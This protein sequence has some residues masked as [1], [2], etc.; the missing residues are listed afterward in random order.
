MNNERGA[1][2]VLVALLMVP[3]LAFGAISIDVG[4]L[5][6]K[7]QQLQTGTDAAALAIA[8]D[9]ARGACGATGT[10]AQSLVVNNLAHGAPTATVTNLTTSSVTVSASVPRRNLFGGAVKVATST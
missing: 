6:V 5:Y 4:G 8:A 10:T 7:K 3:L 2:G 1:S 9:C